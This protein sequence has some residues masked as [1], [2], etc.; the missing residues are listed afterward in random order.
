MSIYRV[1]I[2]TGN[3]DYA[4]TDANV[5]ITIYGTLCNSGERLLDNADDNFEKGKIDTFQIES[6]DLGKLKAIRIRHDDSGRNSGWKLESVTITCESTHYNDEY[7]FNCN[8]WLAT[9]EDDGKI[10]RR[11]LVN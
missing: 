6:R 10:E 8:R 1:K 3:D 4:G 11:L 7:L 5:Y 9:D 2:T